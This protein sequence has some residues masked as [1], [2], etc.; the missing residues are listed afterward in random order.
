MTANPN[1]VNQTSQAKSPDST[2]AAS[3]QR[4]PP[5]SLEAEMCALGSMILDVDCIGELIPIVKKNPESI[6]AQINRIVNIFDLLI[7]IFREPHIPT[8]S[9]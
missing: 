6:I 2:E 5:Q 3:A 4:V 1:Q 7:C 8:T 9:P